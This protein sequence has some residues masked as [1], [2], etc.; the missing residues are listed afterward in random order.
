MKRDRLSDLI[1][2]RRFLVG[3]GAAFA[4]LAA[5]C[6]QPRAPAPTKGNAAPDNDQFLGL[7]QGGK[8]QLL[9]PSGLPGVRLTRIAMQVAQ[10]PESAELD[11][12]AYE[13]QAIMVR[14]R[15]AGGWLYSAEVIDQ[16]G[17]ILTLLVRQVFGQK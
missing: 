14:G 10:S 11:L 4:W 12:A 1:S 3:L 16:A 17:P 6:R 13:G 15:D 2:R 5:A 7:V 9:S 8:F